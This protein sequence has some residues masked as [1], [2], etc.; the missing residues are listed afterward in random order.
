MSK[1]VTIDKFN[2]LQE[3]LE[4]LKAQRA[5]NNYNKPQSYKKKENDE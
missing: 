4:E 1:Y 5:K 3:E 2:A